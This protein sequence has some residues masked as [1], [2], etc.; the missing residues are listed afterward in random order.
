MPTTEEISTWQQAN[1]DVALYLQDAA[2]EGEAQHDL[3][4]LTPDL[5]DI[6][7]AGSVVSPRTLEPL[8]PARMFEATSVPNGE[9]SIIDSSTGIVKH[10]FRI[11]TVR[12]GRLAGSRI[13]KRRHADGIFRGFA[14]LTRSHQV[15]VWERFVQ[16]EETAPH[17][18]D[19]RVAIR[20]LLDSCDIRNAGTFDLYHIVM[21]W[22]IHIM[23]TCPICNVQVIGDDASFPLCDNHARERDNH[24]PQ[25]HEAAMSEENEE[26]ELPRRPRARRSSGPLLCEN[27]T[28][29]IR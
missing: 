10:E 25:E 3:L 13:I 2:S 4:W 18:M 1:P 19:L 11:W 23:R 14:F 15:R 16:T 29:M 12:R 7:R 20:F 6:V 22:R 28:G 27:G 9:W 17:T 26:R 5:T 24:D 8:A 21:D